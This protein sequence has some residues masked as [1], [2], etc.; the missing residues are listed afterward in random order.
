M[1]MLDAILALAALVALLSFVGAAAITVGVDSR[2][3][4]P[5]RWI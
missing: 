3:T 4:E 5:I 1:D 2:P